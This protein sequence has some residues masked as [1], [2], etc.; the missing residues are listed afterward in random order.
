[1]N[2]LLDTH[3]LLFAWLESSS[4]SA[5]AREII[6]NP[7]NELYYSQASVWEICLK[8]KIGKLPLPESPQMYLPACMQRMGMARAELTDA[9]LYRSAEL[10]EH[11][12][13]PFDLILI[14]TAQS[15]SL[16]LLSKD[17]QIQKYDLEVIW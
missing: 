8:Y 6:E 1:M 9:I 3:A 11:H 5:K 17:R 14:A 15:M 16:P 2:V 12:K 4:L 10:P 7:G 13:D